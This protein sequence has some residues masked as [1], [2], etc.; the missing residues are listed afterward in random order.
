MKQDF[1]LYEKK[2]L[3]YF[4]S[5]CVTQKPRHVIQAIN[6]Y[7][8]EF[9]SCGGRSGHQLGRAVSEEVEGARKILQKFFGAKQAIFT[10]NTTESINLVANGFEGT[11]LITDK[12]HN[13]NLV[14]WLRLEQEGKV[15]I[16]ILETENGVID[17]EAF[18]AALDGV[19]L[20]SI[21]HRS[22]IDGI[23]NDVKKLTKLAQKAGAKVL[24]DGAQAA[25]HTDVNVKSI[26]ADY[27]ALSGHKML[28]P[29][30]MGLLLTTEEMRSLSVG[31]DTV[32]NTWHDKYE[33]AEAPRLYEA[34]LQ[35]YAGMIGLGAAAEYLKKAG[36]KK[37]D[38]HC[39]K[40]HSS[41]SEQLQ[42]LGLTLLNDQSKATIT[43]LTGVDADILARILDK[44][45]VL[46][47]SGMFCCH[48][49]FNKYNLPKAVRFSYHC[50]NDDEDVD[51]AVSIIKDNKHML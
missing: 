26:G 28:G 42:D 20:V 9:P 16:K 48:S 50:Y 35:N 15:G 32:N 12:E 7:Y 31:G 43:T 24:I 19:D 38:K 37:I 8:T 51:R 4:D 18:K 10:R 30:G 34:G 33:E 47:R 40:L 14:P 49:Y 5:A 2:D 6:R 1:P 41:M 29:S 11:V 22:N 27:Y 36:V 17:I 39:K 3:A 45:G 23:E 13:S 21:H 46:T 44:E 25:G